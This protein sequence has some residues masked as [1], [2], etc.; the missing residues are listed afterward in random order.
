MDER[1]V[2]CMVGGCATILIGRGRRIC[3]EPCRACS[4]L[5][6]DR[7]GLMFPILH[8]CESVAGKEEYEANIMVARLS[9]V[10]CVVQRQCWNVV[11]VNGRCVM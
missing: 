9:Q 1:L 10:E 11:Y 2:C 7:S 3:S 8:I 6:L 5:C 4:V